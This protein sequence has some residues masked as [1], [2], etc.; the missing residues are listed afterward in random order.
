MDVKNQVK[1]EINNN[2]SLL[3]SYKVNS[4]IIYEV[5]VLIL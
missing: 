3:T 1:Y 4:N 2:L 5:C